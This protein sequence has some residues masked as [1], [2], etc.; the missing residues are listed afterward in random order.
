MTDIGATSDRRYRGRPRLRPDGDTRQIIY[1]AARHEL[2]G[3]GYSATSIDA[4]A[5]RAGVSTKTV[6]RL[7][8]NKAALFE[9]M[10]S[11]RLDRFLADVKLNVNEHADVRDA[12]H[13]A[14]MACAKLTLD[15]EVIALQRIVLQEATQFPDIAAAFYNNGIVRTAAALADWLRA[16]QARG[17][18]ALEDV[19]EAAGMLI[20]MVASAPQ[21]AA[22]FG[23]LPTPSD[24]EIDARVRRCAALFLRGCQVR[25]RDA[26][27]IK[28]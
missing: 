16:Q 8:P 11:D 18:I 19:D 4:V 23:G 6:Y 9:G 17:L 10:V 28:E 13:A 26:P 15:R 25:D 27:L 7:I 22:I 2:A 3:N 24:S 5:R 1:D 20:G 14:L 21:R 12:L